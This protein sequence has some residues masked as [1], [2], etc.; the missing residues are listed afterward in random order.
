[1]R[2]A[3]GPGT[4]LGYCTNVHAAHSFDDLC[5]NLDQHAVAVK[6]RVSPGAPMGV[7]LWLPASAVREVEQ[8]DLGPR[9]RAFLDE[10]GLLAYT[11]NGFPFGDFHADVVKHAVYRPTWAEPARLEY[12]MLLAR[13]LAALLPEGGEGSISTLP[14][15][16]PTDLD[17]DAAIEA[18]AGHLRRLAEGLADLEQRTGRWVHVDLEPEPGCVLDTAADVVDFFERYL[19]D[20][21][22]SERVRRYLGVCHDV[23]HAAV[24]FEPQSE[25][26]RRYRQA[27]VAIG[28]V[29]LSSAVHASFDGVVPSER[30]D[31][32]D[33]LGQF[34]EPR[35][36]HQTMLGS[37]GPMVEDLPEALAAIGPGEASAIDQAWRVHFHVPLF[38]ERFG[39]LGTTMSDV[40]EAIG[41]LAGGAVVRHFEAETYAWGVLPEELRTGSLAEG[42]GRELAWVVDQVGPQGEPLAG[43]GRP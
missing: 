31:V 36:L 21:S 40:R 13:L 26:I 8:R 20:R 17:S 18:A 42:I 14:L 41:L 28:K 38:L 37:A 39:M 35:Y 23:C 33:Q 10:R 32:I 5:A 22:G 2:D 43:R 11:I 34:D 19:L 3:L 25:A 30:P 4:V 12:T 24:M 7:G 1:M 6:Q 16:W 29:Q 9:L 27:G 15:G